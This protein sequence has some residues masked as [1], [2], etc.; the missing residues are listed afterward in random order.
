MENVHLNYGFQF[1]GLIYIFA[2]P[3]KFIEQNNWKQ[4]NHH[5]FVCPPVIQIHHY[6]EIFQVFKKII[7]VQY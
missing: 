5:S 4:W 7:L 2:M 3:K 6:Q 1:T